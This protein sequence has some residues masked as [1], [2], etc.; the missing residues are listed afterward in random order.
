MGK[1]EEVLPEYYEAYDRDIVSPE[2][3]QEIYRKTFSMDTYL[4]IANAISE[5]GVIVNIDG[6]SNRVAA[7]AFGPKQVIMIVGMN[8]ISK[9]VISNED[10]KKKVEEI[11]R[12]LF[13]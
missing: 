5:D 10:I 7:I 1:A 4:T 13:L 11:K 6:M 12:T 9:D 2:E 8:K 3:Q